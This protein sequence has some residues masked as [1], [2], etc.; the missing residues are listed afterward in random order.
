MPDDFKGAVYK[1]NWPRK[2]SFRLLFFR[3]LF[4]II[5]LSVCGEYAKRRKK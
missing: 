4:K 2:N 5:A 3:Y 1:K